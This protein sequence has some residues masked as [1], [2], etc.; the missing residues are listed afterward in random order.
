MPD[1]APFD[2]AVMLAPMTKGSNLPYRRLCDELGATIT[3]GEMAIA[4]KLAKRSR[5]EFALL[6][7]APEEKVFGVQLAGRDPE[8]TAWAAALAVERGADLVDLNCGCPIDEITRRGLGSALL[9]KPGRIRE[10]VAAMVRAVAPKPVTVKIRLGFSDD[11][12]NHLEVAKAAVEGGASA[13]VVH[14]RTRTARYRR[15]ASWEA[16]GEVA[17]AV[18]VPVIGNG[19]LLF[20]HEVPEKLRIAGCAGVMIARGALIKPWIFRE[21]AEGRYLD[22]DAEERLAIYRRYVALARPHFGEDDRGTVRI[23]GFLLWHLDFWTRY[24][25]RFPDGHYP[26]M[27]EREERFEPRSRLEALLSRSDAAA[28]EWLATLLLE[29]DEKAGPPPPLGEDGPEREII[30]EG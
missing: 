12:L 3:M 21:I 14:G 24:V 18:P 10:N 19:D 27:Q 16:I 30:P 17:S 2:G 11:K 6:K 7:R 23:R 4:R 25:P 9:T 8:E 1:R 28:H 5:P 26:R 29:G 15:L 13:L 22:L 20:P